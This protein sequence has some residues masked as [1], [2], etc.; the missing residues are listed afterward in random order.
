MQTRKPNIKHYRIGQLELYN[1][2][3]LENW[4]LSENVE[5]YG[6]EDSNCVR[7]NL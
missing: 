7:S 6:I 2:T 4:N 3:G 1:L 5:V